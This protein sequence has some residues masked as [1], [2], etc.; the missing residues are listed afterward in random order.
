MHRSRA[1]LASLLSLVLVSG[2]RDAGPRRFRRRRRASTARPPRPRARRPPSRSASPTS[3]RRRPRALDKRRRRPPGR[4]RRARPADRLGGEA[5]GPAAR[6]RSS[7]CEAGFEAKQTQIDETQARYKE[8]A[9]LLRGPRRGELQAGQPGSTSS[10]LLELAGHRRPHHAHRVRGPR[11]Q[12]EQRHRRRPRRHARVARTR[13]G[14]AR[15]RPRDRQRQAPGGRGRRE[16]A[17]RPA[18][19][20]AGQ[21]RPA[22]RG[23]RPEVQPA[24]R[25]P[26]NAKRLRAARRRRGSRVRAH[27]R[28]ALAAAARGVY[29]GSMAWPVPG[30]VPRHLAVRLAHPPDLPRRASSTRASTSARRQRLARDR[31]RRCR[32]GHLRGLRAAA[33]ATS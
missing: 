22:G 18:G 2:M 14:R 30:F 3:S 15:S 21:D 8:R 1:Y 19:R 11:H 5:L 28:D 13:A 6:P 10:M 7:G 25:E 23:A 32:A 29:H 26:K 9:G 16:Q 33:T 12:V 31:R 27:R 17:A 20:A 24:R 4:G